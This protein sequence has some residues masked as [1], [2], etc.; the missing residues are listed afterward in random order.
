LSYGFFATGVATPA[1]L[2]AA[3]PVWYGSVTAYASSCCCAAALSRAELYLRLDTQPDVNMGT[4]GF[5][6]APRIAKCD[7]AL[8]GGLISCQKYI[9]DHLFGIA[10][11]DGAPGRSG[12]GGAAKR[13]LDV[14]RH[15]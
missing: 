8:H 10:Q 15:K 13:Q 9:T 7:I 11:L 3:K 12:L 1:A 14:T 2:P 4:T 5:T 6:Y